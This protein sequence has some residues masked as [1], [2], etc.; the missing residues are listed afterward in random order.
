[1][2]GEHYDAVTKIKWLNAFSEIIAV[3]C[4]NQEIL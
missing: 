3:C 4:V 2:Y 1:M